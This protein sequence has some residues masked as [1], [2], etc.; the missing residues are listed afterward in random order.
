MSTALDAEMRQTW[1][2]PL[3]S[4]REL[5]ASPARRKSAPACFES[6]AVS[7]PAR[8]GWVEAEDRWFHSKAEG[9][10]D[11]LFKPDEGVFFHKSTGMLWVE[12]A[13]IGLV[14][15]DLV[16]TG[17]V[18]RHAVMAFAHNAGA[19]AR[20]VFRAWASVRGWSAEVARAYGV[21][22]DEDEA[23]RVRLPTAS[24]GLT[25][26]T[27]HVLRR[28][29]DAPPLEAAWVASAERSGWFSSRVSSDWVFGAAEEV[30]YH[31]KTAS[32]W[33]VDSIFCDAL[34]IDG[35]LPCSI[36]IRRMDAA[37]RC[38]LLHFAEAASGVLTRAC[39]S[40]WR[41]L[42]RQQ[43]AASLVRTLP[44]MGECA[45]CMDHFLVA[46]VVDDSIPYGAVRF[47]ACS[48][49]I[50]TEC[51]GSY[52]VSASEMHQWSSEG[53]PCPYPGCTSRL[54]GEVV[55]GV[56]ALTTAQRDA[57]A[58]HLCQLLIS[59]PV[60][61][62]DPQCGAV[63]DACGDGCPQMTCSQCGIRF[64]RDCR[65]VWHQGL[66]CTE[67]RLRPDA[68][69]MSLIAL[70]SK[71]GWQRCKHCGAMV[72]RV[73]G[74]NHVQCSQCGHHFCYRCGGPFDSREYRCLNEG[75]GI[76]QGHAA[77][78]L[79]RAVVQQIPDRAE[80][81]GFQLRRLFWREAAPALTDQRRQFLERW[82]HVS[83]PNAPSA[84]EALVQRGSLAIMPPW[85]RLALRDHRCPYCGRCGGS[86]KALSEHLRYMCRQHVLTCCDRLFLNFDE[87]NMHV[88]ERHHR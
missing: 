79:Q 41:S 19:I 72:E 40:G 53:L 54:T 32:L 3:Q 50:C 22:P 25:P 70:A 37:W 12:V 83:R 1:E 7:P 23:P 75:C 78:A 39:M 33:K 69:D 10:E 27:V 66:T 82:A 34:P 2:S 13:S 31:A 51:L 88:R 20:L 46:S 21:S 30:L 64:C 47:D 36:V 77:A 44:Q 24:A 42:T 58:D 8:H 15:T 85:Q 18:S 43:R 11:W 63:Y 80:R 73:E 67:Y 76:Y 71:V 5:P 4:E 38:A 68:V 52:A 48:H 81:A 61:C 57:L 16:E 9:A 28:G 29:V 59:A 74:C 17:A 86:S 14:R 6:E 26:T 65:C 84:V 56:A 87:L 60:Y 62:P 35:N 55:L 45:V 49:A